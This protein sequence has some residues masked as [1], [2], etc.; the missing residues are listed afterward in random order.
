MKIIQ[1]IGDFLF[2]IGGTFFARGL[3]GFLRVNAAIIK[4]KAVLTVFFCLPM[5]SILGGTL[6][7]FNRQMNQAYAADIK[8]ALS[9]LAAVIFADMVLNSLARDFFQPLSL[10][11]ET[12]IFL[13]A[14]IVTVLVTDLL[15]LLLKTNSYL[16]FILPAAISFA[17]IIGITWAKTQGYE[18]FSNISGEP[19]F[20]FKNGEEDYKTFRIPSLIVLDREVLNA[21]YGY[22][23]QNDILLATAEARRNS[24]KDTGEID[25]VGKLSSDRGNSWTDLTVFFTDEETACKFG[26]PTPV[27]DKVN[28]VINFVLKGDI[29]GSE[30]V[31]GTLNEDLSITWGE[32]IP[33]KRIPAKNSS[34]ENSANVT[35]GPGKSIQLSSCRLVVPCNN[36]GESLALYSDDYGLT[37]KTGEPAAKGGECEAVELKSGELMLVSR[38]STDCSQYHPR[39]Y[40]RLSYSNDGGETWAV[41]GEATSLKTPVCMSSLDKTSDGTVWFSYPDCFLTRANLSVAASADNGKHWEIT[42]LYPGP[43]GYSCL[44][45]DSDDKVYVLAE[46]GKVNYN[47]ALVFLNIKQD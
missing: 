10:S 5:A 16:S 2:V 37:W 9:V 41:K 36:G 15:G 29:N 24:S 26:N 30:N 44:A 18:K 35:P 28:G 8:I 22:S 19:L 13:I 34:S 23:F 12:C 38:E 40:Q 32:H 1:I 4:Q 46:V 21:K 27:F 45:A 6:F 39:Q 7:F 20:L 43:S 42:R 14:G 17:M 25:L 47:E 31:Q 11:S 33:L 3:I